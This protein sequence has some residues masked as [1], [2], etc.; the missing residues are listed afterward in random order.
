LKFNI[1]DRFN[2][3]LPADPSLRNYRR[4]VEEACFSFVTPRVPSN[5]TL[6][7]VSEEMLLEVGLSK[8]DAQS[9]KFVNVFSGKE[10]LEGTSPYAMCYAGHQFGHWAGQL[11]DG[12]AINLCEV[13]HNNKYW[14]L[15]LKTILSSII[16]HI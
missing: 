5:P 13:E 4:Q 2:R 7:H 1:Q 12:R 11:G 15:Q 9:D 6:V 16:I 8:E 14:T 10:V 3:E